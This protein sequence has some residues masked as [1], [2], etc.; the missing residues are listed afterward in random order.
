LNSQASIREFARNLRGAPSKA[1]DDRTAQLV[2]KTI[3]A[4]LLEENYPLLSEHYGI[5]PTKKVQ[6]VPGYYSVVD[7]LGVG[8]YEPLGHFV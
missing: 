3:L 2:V 7:D 8:M 5:S 4:D 6:K 1:I